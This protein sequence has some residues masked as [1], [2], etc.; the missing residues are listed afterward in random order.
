[1]VQLIKSK[2]IEKILAGSIEIANFPSL[3]AS[4]ANATSVI[5]TALSTAGDGGVAVPLQ[6]STG[7]GVQGVV[8]SGDTNIALV[9]DNASKTPIDATGQN[10]EVYARMTEVAG[11][12]TISYFYL[13]N[14]GVETAHTFSSSTPIDFIFNYRYTFTNFPSDAVVSVQSTQINQDPKTVGTKIQQEQLTVTAT[15]TLSAL[16]QTPTAAIELKLLINGVWYHSGG[17]QPV[18][19]SGNIPTWTP[20]A[21]DPQDAFDIVTNDEVYA[22]Y[23]RV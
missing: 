12:Y 7:G 15:N 17:G 20:G 22:Y 21:F 23:P 14:A 6:P 9:L 5:T 18:G 1:M 10:N 3:A 4:S 2:Q 16:T 8:T 19:L 11:V 13:D